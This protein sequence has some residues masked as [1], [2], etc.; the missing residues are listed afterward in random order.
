MK[1]RGHVSVRTSGSG[2][3]LRP[4]NAGQSSLLG[5]LPIVAGSEL[6]FGSRCQ[7]GITVCGDGRTIVLP[8]FKPFATAFHVRQSMASAC[9]R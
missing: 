7:A 4:D 8:L 2:L 3:P 1:S 5:H 6:S 9:M